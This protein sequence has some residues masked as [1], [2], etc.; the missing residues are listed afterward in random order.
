MD[1]GA[2]GA[3]ALFFPP[4]KLKLRDAAAGC[5]LLSVPTVSRDCDSTSAAPGAAVGKACSRFQNRQQPQMKEKQPT[6]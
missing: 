2:E 4:K 1:V 6:R 5:E 3:T